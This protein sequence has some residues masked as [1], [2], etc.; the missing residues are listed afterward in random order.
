[1]ET[2]KPKLNFPKLTKLNKYQ[3]KINLIVQE[4]A[5][6]DNNFNINIKLSSQLKMIIEV[7]SEENPINLYYRTHLT[8]NDLNNLHPC[9]QTYKNI[10]DIYE[11]INNMINKDKYAIKFENDSNAL[12][13]VLILLNDKDEIKIKLIKEKMSFENNDL[14][15]N[16]FIGNFFYE[17]LNFKKLVLNP[18]FKFNH[19]NEEIRKLKEENKE[20]KNKLKDVSNK[21]IRLKNKANKLQKILLEMKQSNNAPI[22]VSKNYPKKEDLIN[23]NLSNNN[24]INNNYEYD[25]NHNMNNINNI[26]N[27]SQF[28]NNYIPPY[29]NN[30][31][32][33]YFHNYLNYLNTNLHDIDEMNDYSQFY[34]D[35]GELD[36]IENIKEEDDDDEEED[37]DDNTLSNINNIIFNEEEKYNNI[38][39]YDDYNYDEDYPSDVNWIDSYP[40]MYPNNNI[41]I[42]NKKETK[43]ENKKTK[44][45]SMIKLDINDFNKKYGT[46]YKDNQ[47]KKLELGSKNLGNNILSDI[48]KYDFNNL[49]KIYLCENNISNIDN[50]ILWKK[51]TIEKIYFSFNKISDISILAKVNFEKLQ[52]LYLDNNLISDITILSQVNFPILSTLSL[53]DNKI[54]DISILDKVKFKDLLFLDLHRNYIEDIAVFKKVDFPYL[55]ALELHNNKIS[56]IE[57]FDNID[58]FKLERLYL[59]GNDNIDKKKFEKIIE[60]MEGKIKDFKI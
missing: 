13:A 4:K 30:N 26:N 45:E 1:M 28:Y 14:E 57:C 2:I 15:L 17:F 41:N 38:Y 19:N 39:N 20:I 50:L 18:K 8:L 37:E 58:K 21:Y 49:I 36:D 16:E 34:Y 46:Q 3:K 35:N 12:N 6:M 10:S 56:D 53:H 59:D 55:N 47:I 60:K 44:E 32:L 42:I 31:G 40:N 54:K 48:L 7:Y 25:N 29:Y 27:S 33:N 5:S 9:F 52:T 22:K 51:S 43:N 23:S 24:K 11:L